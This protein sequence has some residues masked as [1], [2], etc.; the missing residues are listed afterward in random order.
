MAKA[1]G[2][3]RDVLA[4]GDWERIMSMGRNVTPNEHLFLP[5]EQPEDSKDVT[6]SAA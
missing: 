4:T 1:L 2:R 6:D 5:D 3:D